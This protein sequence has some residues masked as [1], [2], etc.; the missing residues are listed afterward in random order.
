MELLDSLGELKTK[1][2]EQETPMMDNEDKDLPQGLLGGM[3]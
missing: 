3:V 2:K 1:D